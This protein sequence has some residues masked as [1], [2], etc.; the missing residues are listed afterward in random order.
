VFQA[1]VTHTSTVSF[2]GQTC[3]AQ[4][5]VPGPPT[6]VAAALGSIVVTWNPPAYPGTSPITS[7]VVTASPTGATYTVDGATTTLRIENPAPGTYTFTVR[8]VNASGAVTVVAGV[9]TPAAAS[10]IVANPAFTG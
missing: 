7:Y 9:A 1:T 10:P 4:Q 8:A 5:A 2:T 6:N 3:G